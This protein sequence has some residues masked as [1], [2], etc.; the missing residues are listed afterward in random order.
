MLS[1][2]CCVP[3]PLTAWQPQS[4]IFQT[5]ETSPIISAS[6]NI[7]HPLRGLLGYIQPSKYGLSFKYH[8]SPA[9]FR[10]SSLIASTL[11]I[12]LGLS[13]LLDLLAQRWTKRSCFN[14]PHLPYWVVTSPRAETLSPSQPQLS[15][16]VLVQGLTCDMG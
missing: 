2:Q 5:S 7:V 10:K 8:T 9:T 11:E 16:R 1:V 4:D 14:K 13:S 15:H 12:S 3:S 6:D